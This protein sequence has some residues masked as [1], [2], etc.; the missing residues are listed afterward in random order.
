MEKVPIVMLSYNRP[1]YLYRTLRSLYNTNYDLYTLHII[2]NCSQDE[3][4]LSLLKSI[5]IPSEI[6]FLSAPLSI[7]EAKNIGIEHYLKDH[8]FP[9]IAIF[10]DDLIF[11]EGC[12]E[13]LTRLY[14]HLP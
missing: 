3:K 12:L 1:E 2:D 9:Y 10:D 11:K 6:T 13:E 4:T 14:L 8:S 5:D 7:G